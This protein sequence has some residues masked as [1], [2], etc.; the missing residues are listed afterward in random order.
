MKTDIQDAEMD[1]S[2]APT[3]R[4]NAT[5]NTAAEAISQGKAIQAIQTPYATAVAVQRPRDLNIVEKRCI[6]EAAKLGESAYYGW[7]TGKDRVEGPSVDCALIAARN[8]GNCAVPMRPM[9]ETE[10]SYVFTAS[11]VDLETGYTLDR[12]FRQSKKWK[13][14]GK[15]D[16]ER[17]EDIRF[18][19]GQ[20]KAIR[21]VVLNALPQWLIDRMIDTAKQG[22]RSSLE[23]FIKQHGI[24]KAQDQM[25]QGFGKYSVTLDRVE[26]KIG[27]KLRA[28]T[29]EDL[30]VLKGDLHAVRTETEDS[31]VL[32][33]APPDKGTLDVSQMKPG[34]GAT[35]TGFDNAP[36]GKVDQA[37][38]GEKQES[39]V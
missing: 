29:V 2:P 34:D 30:I 24:E 22:V 31:S 15:L 38:T 28:W 9:Q 37:S 12:Q 25:V 11:F 6:E 14:Y 32:F 7:G 1:L 16:E 36:K 33:P 18:Q 13:V 39:L 35:N 17:K 23:Q 3:S 21:N 20:S 8:W 26:Y 4:V 19:I 5:F 10:S 27:K